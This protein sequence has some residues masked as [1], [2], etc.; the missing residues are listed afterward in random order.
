MPALSLCGRPEFFSSRQC[1][2]GMRSTP[3]QRQ[4]SC[5]PRLLSEIA[6]RAGKPVEPVCT[7]GLNRRTV[8]RVNNDQSEAQGRRCRRLR[9]N[10]LA[11]RRVRRNSTRPMTR[12]G[13]IKMPPNHTEPGHTALL[14][15]DLPVRDLPVPATFPKRDAAGTPQAA[16]DTFSARSL[17]H[18]ST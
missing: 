6:C 3:E 4:S 2:P 11:V 18:A 5:W 17:Y 8:D 13:R 9:V 14:V 16:L 1:A 7:R 15:R 12:R 10:A